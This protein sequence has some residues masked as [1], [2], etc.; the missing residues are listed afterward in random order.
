MNAWEES[1]RPF[2]TYLFHIS[3]NHTNWI[4]E[5]IPLVFSMEVPRFLYKTK[6]SYKFAQY[7]ETK[8]AGGND[9]LQLSTLFMTN[10][11]TR[12]LADSDADVLGKLCRCST[13]WETCLKMGSTCTAI[14]GSEGFMATATSVIHA[15]FLD[16]SLLISQASCWKR[17]S[18]TPWLSG[19]CFI[20]KIPCRS[21]WCIKSKVR[22][23]DFCYV[24]PP[25]K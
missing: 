1:Q 12:M 7:I 17:A 2:K 13:I 25:E 3:C 5:I 24:H 10:I 18:K 15:S 19:H 8:G 4:Y 21:T 23:I 9:H 14:I 22:C 20:D 16:V 11:R 6:C